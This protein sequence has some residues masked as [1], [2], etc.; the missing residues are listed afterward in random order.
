[1]TPFIYLVDLPVQ[2][3][4][5]CAKHLLVAAMVALSSRSCRESENQAMTAGRPRLEPVKC[6]GAA[7][8][9]RRRHHRQARFAPCPEI[10]YSAPRFVHGSHGVN[11]SLP[12]G[13]DQFLEEQPARSY[14]LDNR[15][16]GAVESGGCDLRANEYTAYGQR[17][18]ELIVSVIRLD[19]D[20]ISCPVMTRMVMC[21][22][23]AVTI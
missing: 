6:S 22:S 10:C 13:N 5:R 11:F 7:K 18:A 4:L 8:A 15:L 9:K 12:G 21:E 16:A 3:L 20:G 23:R 17:T 19:A 1:L 2:D 14:F